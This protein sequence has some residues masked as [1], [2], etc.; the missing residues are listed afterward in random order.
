MWINKKRGEPSLNMLQFVSMRT[1][2]KIDDIFRLSIW[3]SVRHRLPWLVLGLAGGL[4]G[5]Q[6][7][8]QFEGLLSE[9]LILAAYIPLIVYMSDA[10]GTQME[11]YEI[12]DMALHPTASFIK[13]LLR[14]MTIVIFLGIA[15][16]LIVSLVN[17]FLLNDMALVLV[18]GISLCLSIFTS[19]FTGL[20]I[21]YL[22]TKADF[23]PANAS[24]PIAT[25]IQDLVSVVV[26]FEIAHLL[27]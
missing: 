22:F 16:G 23:D 19:I 18:I 6:I 1:K 7:I 3:Q 20:L 14:Q 12:R 27:L 26:Y 24:G 4:I 17:F 15:V 9:R 13:Y 11:A 2:E 10:V 25:I 8:H 5:A 21:P